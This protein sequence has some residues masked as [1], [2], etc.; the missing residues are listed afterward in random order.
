MEFNSVGPPRLAL[1]RENLQKA[2]FYFGLVPN[3][4]LYM[5]TDPLCARERLPNHEG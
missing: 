3:H 5:I 1:N 2:S 4:Y